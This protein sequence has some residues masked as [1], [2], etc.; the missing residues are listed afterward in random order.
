MTTVVAIG[1]ADMDVVIFIGLACLSIGLIAG[2][3]VG[4]DS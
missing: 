4:S 3:W 2:L 1:L